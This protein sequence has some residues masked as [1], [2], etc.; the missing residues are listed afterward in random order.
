[1]KSWPWWSRPQFGHFGVL[2]GHQC[3]NDRGGYLVKVTGGGSVRI[4]DNP[5]KGSA[6][7]YVVRVR[8]QDRDVSGPSGVACNEKKGG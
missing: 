6:L 3:I 1:M 4:T 2:L 7:P 5:K 8:T